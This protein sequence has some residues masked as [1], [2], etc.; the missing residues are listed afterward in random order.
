MNRS[1]REIALE[2]CY[3]VQI[4]HVLIMIILLVHVESSEHA[5]LVKAVTVWH[6]GKEQTRNA[7]EKLSSFYLFTTHSWSGIFPPFHLPYIKYRYEVVC[8]FGDEH[9]PN[10]DELTTTETEA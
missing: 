10:L 2:F 6:S 4:S 8:G 7:S 9:N 3:Y 5:N 1:E